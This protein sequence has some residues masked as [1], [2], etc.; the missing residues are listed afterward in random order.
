[1]FL[2]DVFWDKIYKWKE[3]VVKVIKG[4]QA[5]LLMPNTELAIAL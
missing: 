2:T 4:Q 3:Y 5:P 1:M